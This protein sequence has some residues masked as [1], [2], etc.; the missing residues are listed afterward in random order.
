MAASSGTL[1]LFQ[2]AANCLPGIEIGVDCK[3]T[4]LERMTFKI[5]RKPF[6]FVR[7]GEAKLKL[8]ASEAHAA[9]LARA[10]PSRYKVESD[11]WVELRFE[12]GDAIPRERIEHWVKESYFAIAPGFSD[13]VRRSP[14]KPN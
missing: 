6:L 1:R 13:R 3:G 4:S 10:E 5:G 12:D 11:G 14:K 9:M 8:T 7:A 2:A